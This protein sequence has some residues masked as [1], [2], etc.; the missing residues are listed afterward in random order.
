LDGVVHIKLYL[1][2][3]LIETIRAN[4]GAWEETRRAVEIDPDIHDRILEI[5]DSYNYG[6]AHQVA[7]VLELLADLEG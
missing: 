7:D 3:V 2:A 5:M 1:G 4:N 6:D